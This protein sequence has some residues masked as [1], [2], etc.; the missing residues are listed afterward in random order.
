M[1]KIPITPP[2]EDK[3]FVDIEGLKIWTLRNGNHITGFKASWK[4][5][6]KQFHVVNHDI[7][8]AFKQLEK[9]ISS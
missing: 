6:E 1:A 2:K 3:P 5:K 8:K 9:F 4:G 7:E